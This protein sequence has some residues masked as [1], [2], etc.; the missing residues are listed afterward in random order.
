MK[1]TLFVCW[2]AVMILLA[3]CSASPAPGEQPTATAAPTSTAV[4]PT[5]TTLPPTAVPPTFTPRPTSTRRPSTATPTVTATA[6]VIVVMPDV[7]EPLCERP[8]SLLETEVDIGGPGFCLVWLDEFDDERGFRVYLDYFQSGERFVYEV[9]PNVTQLLVPPTDAPRLDESWQ[10]CLRR[11]AYEVKV[12]ALR[13]GI[14]WPVGSMAVNT[15]C[16]S[17]E[18]SSLPTATA[19]PPT[20]TLPPTALPSN[21]PMVYANQRSAAPP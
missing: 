14:E 12:V 10:Q 11:M 5:A 15:E 8:E 7:N 9:G 13:P 19:G 16:G 4:L 1:R 3:G 2:F 17:L 21:S 18:G 20:P 6:Q